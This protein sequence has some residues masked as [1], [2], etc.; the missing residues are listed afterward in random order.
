MFASKVALAAVVFAASGLAAPPAAAAPNRIARPHTAPR[1]ATFSVRIPSE[2]KASA[3]PKGPIARS[4]VDLAAQ[5]STN[6]VPNLA[7]AGI[8][9]GLSAA[10][11]AATVSAAPTF[12]VPTSAPA[13]PPPIPTLPAATATQPPADQISDPVTQG[14]SCGGWSLQSNYGDRWPAASTWWEYSCTYATSQYYPHPC[15]PGACDAVCY[16]YPVDCYWVSQTSTDYFYWDGSNAVFYGESYSSSIDDGMGYSSSSS[17]WWDAPTAQWYNLGPF[18]LTMSTAGAGSGTV[19]V[20]PGAISCTSGC[21][22][23]FD[24]GTVVTLTA[25]P[26]PGSTFTGWSGDCSGTG[27]CQLAMSQD[28]SV[29]ATFTPNTRSLTVSKQGAGAGAGTGLVSSSPAGISC[30]T[31]CQTSF[32]S[33]STVTLSAAPDPGSVFAGW[34]GDCSGTG[35]CQL[36]M[37]QARSVTA[38]FTPNT[39]GLTV[40]RQGAGTGLVSSSPAGISCGTS[41][42]TSFASGSTVTLSAAPDPGSVFAGWSGDCSGTGS[43]QLTMSQARSVTATFAPNLPPQA[44]FTATCTS[45]TC[46]LN[47]SASSDPDDAIVNYAWSFGDGTSGSGQTTTHTY[48]KAGNY[49]V[50]LTV[51]DN[52]GASATTSRA[53]NPISLSARAY[54]QNSTEKVALSWNTPGGTTYDIYR[55][56]TR[57]ASLQGGSYTDT[58]ASRGTFTY[59]V[60]APTT[61]TCSNQTSVSF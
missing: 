45:L 12:P 31:S 36:T 29:T 24:S 3:G 38:T 46:T 51:T 23:S 61:S 60:C 56:N 43:C 33:G 10:T 14:A 19:G 49:T 27:S 11:Q 57:I 44:S 13:G 8:A 54:K 26:D 37:S 18:M 55:N 2:P 6:V 59:K 52:A 20:S 1:V 16:G 4:T 39:W 15:G 34:S 47:A 17:A 40:S 30:G 53:F 28:R 58:L 50:R 21:Q 22:S 35:S 48:P 42:Q 32:A 9:L 41:C 5:P 25:S 7:V